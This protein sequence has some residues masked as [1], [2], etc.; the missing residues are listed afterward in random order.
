MQLCLRNGK[1]RIGSKHIG[2]ETCT[3]AYLLNSLDSSAC[4]VCFAEYRMTEYFVKSLFQYP[5]LQFQNLPLK[6]HLIQFRMLFGH[7]H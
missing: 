2:S 5:G 4:R 3:L 6:N 7:G 1:R